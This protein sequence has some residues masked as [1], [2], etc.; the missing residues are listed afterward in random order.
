[1]GTGEVRKISGDGTVPYASM[2]HVMTWK[3]AGVDVECVEMPGC[4]HRDILGDQKM[5]KVRRN[6]QR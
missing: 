5:H 2:R 1:M 3:E 6:R 4:L